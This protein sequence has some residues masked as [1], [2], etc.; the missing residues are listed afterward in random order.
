MEVKNHSLTGGI[1]SFDA[2]SFCNAHTN[3]PSSALRPLISP[4]SQVITYILLRRTRNVASF[5]GLRCEKF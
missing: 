5:A 1:K 2:L 3:N 4:N